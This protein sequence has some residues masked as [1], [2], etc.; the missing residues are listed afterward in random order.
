MANEI[1]NSDDVQGKII[2]VRN[3]QV[4]LDRDVATLYGVETRRIN[5]AVKNNP[6]KFPEGYLFTLSD[7]EKEEVVENFDHL[8]VIKFSPVSPTAFTERGLY[9]LATILKSKQAVQTTIAIID[10][11]AQVREM[12]RTMEALQQATGDREKQASLLHRSGELM[13]EVIGQNLSTKSVE[14]EIEL[15]FAVVKIKHKVIRKDG[16]K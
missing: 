11:F 1:I 15:N 16:E 4:L 14:T 3:Q 9:M 7:K 10:T 12:A 2:V 6:E 8:K 5:E 13:A